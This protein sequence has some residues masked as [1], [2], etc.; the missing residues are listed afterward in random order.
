MTEN[1]ENVIY[2]FVAT[3]VSLIEWYFNIVNTKVNFC[4]YILQ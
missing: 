2:L 4:I 1:S 3:L